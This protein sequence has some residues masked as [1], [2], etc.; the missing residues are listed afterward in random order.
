LR[1]GR[2][3]RTS[4][5]GQAKFKDSAAFGLI[6]QIQLAAMTP[7]QFTGNRQAKASTAATA[8]PYKRLKQAGLNAF[9]NAW[10]CI[11]QPD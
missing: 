4:A 6:N 9:W 11:S 3:N 7:S 2:R 8:G 10:T 1:L 5:P